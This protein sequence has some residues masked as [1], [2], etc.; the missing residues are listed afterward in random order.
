MR[1]LAPVALLLATLAL[2]AGALAAP[3]GTTPDT[4][5]AA[6]QQRRQWKEL[7]YGLEL[8]GNFLQGNANLLNVSGVL[9]LNLNRGPHQLYLDAGNILTQAGSATLVNRQ[10]GSALYAY[11]LRDNFNFYGY[12]THASDQATNLSQ[13]F[14]NG[15]GVCL[16][17]LGA[18]DFPLFLVSLGPAYESERYRTGGSADTWRSVLR[19]NA[20]RP[21]SP[22]LELSADTFYT[23]A[24]P[25]MADFRLY[26]EATLKLKLSETLA[27]KFTAADEYDSRPLPGVQNN[28]FG[29]FTTLAAEWGR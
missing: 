24:V 8:S 9:S 21:L 18:P 27:L 1:R 29:L 12:T 5:P 20:V 14:T 16:H 4:R 26:G 15:L 25:D 11:G 3:V 23:P 17:R 22:G 19:V 10:S 7:G 6:P 28:D 2:P 13:R